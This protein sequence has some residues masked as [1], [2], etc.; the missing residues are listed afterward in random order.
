MIFRKKKTKKKK[1]NSYERG[2]RGF[3]HWEKGM[4]SRRS[5]DSSFCPS[6]HL[7]TIKLRGKHFF[8]LQEEKNDPPPFIDSGEFFF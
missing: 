4:D 7:K 2:S 1:K 5:V 6:A 8:S 3:F